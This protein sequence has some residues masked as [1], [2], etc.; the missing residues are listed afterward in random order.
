MNYVCSIAF[1]SA[2]TCLRSSTC[3]PL[4]F[5]LRGNSRS[6]LDL[7][8]PLHSQ[9]AG[10]RRYARQPPLGKPHSKISFLDSS[11][12]FHDS[13]S[14]NTAKPKPGPKTLEKGLQFRDGPLSRNEIQDI[15]GNTVQDPAFANRLLTV[16]YSRMIDGTLDLPPPEDVEE[17]LQDYPE[18]TVE[19]ALEWLRANHPVDEDKAIAQRIKREEGTVDSR[20]PS[21]L[22]HRAGELGL[23]R[24]QSGHYHMPLSDKEGDVYG[25]SEIDRIRAENLAEVEREDA[26]LEK[27]IEQIQS[28]V[29]ATQEAQQ[30][31]DTALTTKPEQGVTAADIE[32]RAPNSFEKWL[33]LSRQRATS[34]ITLSS[35]E[36]TRL[37][38]LR[39]LWPS[40]LFV[41]LISVASLIY[42]ISYIPPA[43]RDRLLPNTSL[44]MTTITTIFAMNLFVWALWKFPP[45]WRLLN[46]YFISVPGLPRAPAM[47]GTV[48]SHQSLRHLL[49][50]FSW[51]YLIGLPLHED[52]GRGW[53]VAT[54]VLAGTW[55]SFLSL[56]N[57]TLRNIMTT[58]TLGASGAATGV[59]SAYCT[60][61][62]FDRFQLKFLSDVEGS[63]GREWRDRLS[64]QGWMFLALLLV[65]EM[66][67]YL[68]PLKTVDYASH[69]AGYAVGGTCGWFWRV[70]REGEESGLGDGGRDGMRA[71]V[72]GLVKKRPAMGI[73][74]AL[75]PETDGASA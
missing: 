62:A 19:S 1:R 34:K 39:R 13:F 65:S 17:Y 32:P 73:E 68:G 10:P 43:R 40:L 60:V 53:F 36:V 35:P 11:R 42:A 5:A 56:T 72:G 25:P 33:L 66:V 23:Y 9:A 38:K 52:I 47:L 22:I 29:R 26:E 28:E 6:L 37:T 74:L 3:V 54:F 4:A 18:T 63:S 57:F 67:G 16:L 69:L 64:V 20:S 27:Q 31:R 51:I 58:S 7:L 14:R 15:F 59:V 71:G 75:G 30:A 21:Q 8:R 45:A 50:N 2:G 61:H 46:K 48:F 70:R 55:G 41:L 12:L 49:L 24:P 44:A